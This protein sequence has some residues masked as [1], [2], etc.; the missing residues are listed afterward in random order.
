MH[1]TQAGNAKELLHVRETAQEK[2]HDSNDY[3]KERQESRK[4]IKH[5]YWKL[6][7]VT[8]IIELLIIRENQGM[9]EQWIFVN[10][11]TREERNY[12]Y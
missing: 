1:L 3:I 9:S 5:I 8:I 2:I 7:K 4:L 12:G 11:L 10:M 6:P